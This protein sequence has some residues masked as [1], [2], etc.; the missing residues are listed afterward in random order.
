M[1]DASATRGH[2]IEILVD[3]PA[4]REFFAMVLDAAEGWDG[5]DRLRALG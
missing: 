2:D 4:F 5:S 1:H 3:A